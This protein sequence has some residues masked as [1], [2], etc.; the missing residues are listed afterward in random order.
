[1]CVYLKLVLADD[2]PRLQ[3]LTDLV[4]DGEHGDV[5]FASTGGCAD[6]QVFI[7]V[8]SCLEHYRLDSVQ[9]FHAL[10]H[11]LANLQTCKTNFSGLLTTRSCLEISK[12]REPVQCSVQ[13]V[14]DGECMCS[15]CGNMC[16][17]DT[18]GQRDRAP[19]AK[20]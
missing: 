2:S 7:G 9:P 5:G 19:G 11:Q 13:E 15:R 8:V 3:V 18:Y 12:Y 14:E 1:M 16:D 4:E 17:G 6:E 10:E 20:T